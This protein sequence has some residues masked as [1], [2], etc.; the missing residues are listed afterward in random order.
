[1]ARKG[2]NPVVPTLD[3]KM[4]KVNGLKVLTVI[5]V[6]EHLKIRCG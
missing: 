3:N 1:M 6:D 4:S 2:G 5:K